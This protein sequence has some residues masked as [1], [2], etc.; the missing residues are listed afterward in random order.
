M[1]LHSGLPYW[2]VKNQLF[3]FFHPLERDS[4][5]AA[6]IISNQLLGKKDDRAEIFAF[7]RTSKI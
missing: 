1:D 2:I 4:M 3:D 7:D 5:I 6:Q